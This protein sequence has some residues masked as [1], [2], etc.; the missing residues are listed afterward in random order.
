MWTRPRSAMTWTLNELPG[1]RKPAGERDTSLE[2]LR[3]Y[4]ALD[5]ND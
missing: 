4:G 2:L 3:E 1:D 5:A